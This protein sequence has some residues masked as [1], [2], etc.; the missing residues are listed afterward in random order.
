MP[1]NSGG[2]YTPASGAESAVP[3][4]LI[5]SAVWNAIFTDISSALT[6][7]GQ[8]LYGT[9]MV[10]TSPY[11]PVTADTFLQVNKASAVTINLPTAS[12]RNGYPL[13]IKDVSG[14]AQTN[15]ITINPNG[16]DT[17]EGLTALTIAVAYGGYI[18]YPVTGGWILSP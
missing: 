15:V 10:S 14:V 6:L 17:I 4:G 7:L 2:L 18:L 13:I 12:S 3:G 8:Q 16:A 9:T 11:V 1:F 5:Q